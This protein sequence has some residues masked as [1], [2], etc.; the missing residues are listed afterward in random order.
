MSNQPTDQQRRIA[1]LAAAL[2]DSNLDAAEA[3]GRL[4]VAEAE[5]R[6][7]QQGFGIEIRWNSVTERAELRQG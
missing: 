2:A 3:L 7:Q 5:R 6:K 1:Q 4:L